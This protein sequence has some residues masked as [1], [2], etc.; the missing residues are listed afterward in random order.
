[1]NVEFLAP[2]ERVESWSFEDSRW[3]LCEILL[4]LINERGNYMASVCTYRVA[5][6][7]SVIYSD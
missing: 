4:F 3:L 5:G 7:L 6:N 2:A 1:M